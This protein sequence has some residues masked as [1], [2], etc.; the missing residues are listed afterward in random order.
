MDIATAAECM[1]RMRAGPLDKEAIAALCKKVGAEQAGQVEKVWLDMDKRGV[2]TP[3]AV[4]LLGKDEEQE[5]TTAEL[6]E[7]VRLVD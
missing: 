3:G 7:M 6:I 5:A 4:F 2:R 1:G